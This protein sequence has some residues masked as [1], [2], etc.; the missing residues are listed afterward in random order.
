MFTAKLIVKLSLRSSNPPNGPC[1]DKNDRGLFFSNYISKNCWYRKCDKVNSTSLDYLNRAISHE[2]STV[3]CSVVLLRLI[4]T[5]ALELTMKYL[6]CQTK[7]IH[8][9]LN[10]LLMSSIM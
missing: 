4:H 9:S 1:D 2:K 3:F 5:C 10:I 7:F 8:L 6:I